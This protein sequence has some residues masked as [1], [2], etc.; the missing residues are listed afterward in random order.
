MNKQY[1]LWFVFLISL[2]VALPSWAKLTPEQEVAKQK[3]ILLYQQSRLNETTENYLLEAAEAGDV[4]A[5]VYL[6]IVMKVTMPLMASKWLEKAANQGDL[7][8]M[9]QLS[10][11]GAIWDQF[12]YTENTNKTDW[13]K[14]GTELSLE[15]AK[16]GDPE[17]MH[18]YY[19]FT[20]DLNWLKKSA[21]LGWLPAQE[22]IT[23]QVDSGKPP[24]DK[25]TKPEQEEL[26]RQ[27]RDRAIANGSL[28]IKYDTFLGY[29]SKFQ[30]HFYID[31]STA[32]RY[33]LELVEKSYLRAVK[34]YI[35]VLNGDKDY[36][37]LGV[38][39]APIKA[40]ALTAFVLDSGINSLLSLEYYTEGVT[41]IDG[42]YIPPLTTEQIKQGYALKEQW[43]KTHPPLRNDNNKLTDINKP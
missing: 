23:Y 17:A 11:D 8:A 12:G 16:Q 43:A 26:Y 20:G 30:S 24:F 35:S 40:Y 32:Q 39:P 33:L 38:K 5:M 29:N 7:Y 14:K 6:G 37:K 31:H 36:K 34:I 42:R 27:Y 13:K 4:E 10:I 3:G 22:D 9:Y 28:K 25:L 41:T 19:K 15:R 21:D 2:L 18:L 1:K